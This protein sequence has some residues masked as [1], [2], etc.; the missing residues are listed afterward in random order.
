MNTY[1]SGLISS[2][3][4]E[5]HLS[6]TGQ[7]DIPGKRLEQTCFYSIRTSMFTYFLILH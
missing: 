4:H 2:Q 1:L 7:S 6:S 5:P 3:S